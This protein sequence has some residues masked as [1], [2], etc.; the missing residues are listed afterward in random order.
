MSYLSRRAQSDPKISQFIK[1]KQPLDQGRIGNPSDLD[2]AAVYFMSDAS[3]FTTGQVLSVDGV[4]SLS[5][6][7]I[8]NET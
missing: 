3:H 6:G 2:S 7:Q 8:P 4:W 5:D 1:T